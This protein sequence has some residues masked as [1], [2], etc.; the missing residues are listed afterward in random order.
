ME[1]MEII[2]GE[3][4]SAKLNTSLNQTSQDVRGFEWMKS[5]KMHGQN[6]IG[7]TEH[8]SRIL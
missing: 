3:R 6:S 8:I 5:S 2:P 7:E 1:E 4:M